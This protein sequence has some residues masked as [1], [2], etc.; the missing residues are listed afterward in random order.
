MCRLGLAHQPVGGTGAGA[1]LTR[2]AGGPQHVYDC[3]G[4][5]AEARAEAGRSCIMN[6]PDAGLKVRDII[7]GR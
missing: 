3:P 2:L 7:W 1:L 5:S 6:D 4:S